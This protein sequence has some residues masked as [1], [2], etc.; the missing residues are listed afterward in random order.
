MFLVSFECAAA[1]PTRASFPHR[2]A[3]HVTIVGQVQIGLVGVDVPVAA[4]GLALLR[5]FSAAGARLAVAP[6]PGVLHAVLPVVLVSRGL[7]ASVFLVFLVFRGPAVVDALGLV[8]RPLTL[9]WH[10]LYLVRLADV[11]NVVLAASV[12]VFVFLVVVLLVSLAAPAA[13]A[14]LAVAALGV[15]LAWF[16]AHAPPLAAAVTAL[17]GLAAPTAAVSVLAAA[18]LLFAACAALAALASLA[19]LDC[20]DAAHLF[21]GTESCNKSMIKSAPGGT[22]Q[23]L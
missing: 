12:V 7:S 9:D 5:R 3:S 21:L 6:F 22:Q 15:R 1:C 16:A 20:R 23:Q 2:G 4:R 18:L 10:A 17:A 11:A 14:F 8:L 19:A 13:V